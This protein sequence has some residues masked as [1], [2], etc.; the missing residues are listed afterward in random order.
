MDQ[1][2]K[3]GDRLPPLIAVVA[4]NL[5]DG[6]L[7]WGRIEND[8]IRLWRYPF[9]VEEPAKPASYAGGVR[10]EVMS[11]VEGPTFLLYHEKDLVMVQ[12]A[13]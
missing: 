8:E 10:V 2:E 1:V 4:R 5:I 11:P 3:A 13:A 12:V 6:M 7:V 9:L